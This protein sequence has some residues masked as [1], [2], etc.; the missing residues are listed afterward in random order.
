MTSGALQNSLGGTQQ[1]MG[2]LDAKVALITG[3]GSGIGRAT[4]ILFAQK[5]AKV[6]AVDVDQDGAS[7]A[8][9]EITKA[10]GQAF[11]FK[12]DVSKARDAEAMVAEAVRRYGRLDIIYNNAGI[13]F[14][15]QVHSM[16]EEEWDRM[17]SI[18]LKG[19]FLG[20]KYALAE[21]MQHGGVI[22]ATGSIAGL[23]GHNGEPHYG[24]AKAGVVNLMKSIAMDYAHYNIR[25]NCVCPGGVQTNIAKGIIDRIPPEQLV[26]MGQLALTHSLI[27]RQAQPEEIARA[28]LFLCSDDA[29]FITGHTLVVDGGWTAGHRMAF[30][31]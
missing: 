17:L 21:L 8:V 28:A 24:A 7:G 2:K 25:A 1:A 31:D 10:G 4:A 27:K 26:K 19:V 20:C 30:F 16:T 11:A 15:A 9:A 22:L 5:G 13:F 14:P 12:A 6:A 18:N 3:A 23:E 29:S